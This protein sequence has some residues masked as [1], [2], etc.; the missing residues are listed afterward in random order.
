MKPLLY[1]TSNLRSCVAFKRLNLTELRKMTPRR[2]TLRSRAPAAI[3]TELRATE[4]RIDK[5]KKETIAAE[6]QHAQALREELA[7]HPDVCRGRQSSSQGECP[8]SG[9]DVGAPWV[10]QVLDA[11]SGVS[12][13]VP[14]STAAQ[15]MATYGV[16]HMA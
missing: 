2:I 6:E 8:E 1:V 5:A 14:L 7:H 9:W 12:S 11:S 16:A 3:S 4:T 10:G 15:D 13:Q